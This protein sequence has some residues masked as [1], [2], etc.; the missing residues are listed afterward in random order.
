MISRFVQILFLA[1]LPFL[2]LAEVTEQQQSR[3][4]RLGHG[5]L[6]PCCYKEPVA[7]HQSEIS[8][9]MRLEIAKWV[10]AGRSDQE[11]IDTYVGLHGSKVL[12]DPRTAPRGWMVLLPWLA[13]I[14]GAFLVAWLLRRWRAAPE[15]STVTALSATEAPNL[16]DV[17]DD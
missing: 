9:K 17:N 5:L 4:E 1:L 6:A 2:A 3:I 10:A 16:P 14:A 7:T 15:P 11:I 8:V 13:L 12:V